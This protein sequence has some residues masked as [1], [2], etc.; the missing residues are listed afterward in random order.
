MLAHARWRAGAGNSPS[1]MLMHQVLSP[2]AFLQP[3]AALVPRSVGSRTNQLQFWKVRSESRC[4]ARQYR[5]PKVGSMRANN[6]VGQQSRSSAAASSVHCTGVASKVKRSA[7]GRSQVQFSGGDERLQHFNG[8]KTA[9]KLGV[10]HT[11]ED[12]R[13]A[14]APRVELRCRPIGPAWIATGQVDQRA[15]VDEDRFARLAGPAGVVRPGSV[16]SS[17]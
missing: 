15:G 4:V 3:L 16:A 11:V 13:A 8:I 14:F 2:L 7:T 9:C 12:E 10:H 5:T 1:L 6:K 17:S